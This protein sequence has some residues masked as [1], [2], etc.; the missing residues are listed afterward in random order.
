MILVC[1]L[2]IYFGSPSSQNSYIGILLM[3]I[4]ALV[5]GSSIKTTKE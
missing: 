5:L 2:M 1:A 3:L 4:M